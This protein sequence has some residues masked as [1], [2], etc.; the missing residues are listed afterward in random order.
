MAATK[1]WLLERQ[2]NQAR[3]GAILPDVTFEDGG[4]N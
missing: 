2:K 3:S 1:R 4:R